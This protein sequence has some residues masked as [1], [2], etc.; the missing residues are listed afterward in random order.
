MTYLIHLGIII[1]IF[2]ILAVSLNIAIGYA[3]MLNLGH[4]AFYGIGAYTSAILVKA[5]VAF[6]LALL[7]AGVMAALCGALLTLITNRLKGDYFALATLGFTFVVYSLMLNWTSLTRGPLG[8]PGIRRPELFGF[9]VRTNGQYLVYVLAILG[10][11]TGF[12]YLLTRS[13][14]GKLLEAV[15][16]DAIGAA[17]LGK[18]VFRLKVQAMMISAF[19]AGIA[20]SL[21][22][23]YISF[24]DPSTFFINDIIILVTIVIVG[25]LASVKGNVIGAL[26]I[27]LVPELLRFFPL[28]PQMIGPMRQMLYA[29]ILIGILLYRPRG[30]FGRV[31]LPS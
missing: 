3:G 20:G 9:L 7:A 2:A 19:F 5:G 15:R 26:I 10:L 27:I 14:Y 17:A 12:L 4:V 24:I 25:G 8:I 21:Y 28:P 29:L 30:L 16:D 18:N 13:R 11:T 6:P 23:H 31:D 1:T 22:A